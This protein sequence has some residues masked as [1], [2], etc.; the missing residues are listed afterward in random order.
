MHFISTI[1][2]NR[3]GT[4]YSHARIIHAW[5]SY[6][7]EK[8]PIIQ[9]TS[10]HERKSLAFI[11]RII[12][13]YSQWK[14]MFDNGSTFGDR[15]NGTLLRETCFTC[16]SSLQMYRVVPCFNV[17]LKIQFSGIF[18]VS[19]WSND[20]TEHGTRR[21]KERQTEKEEGKMIYKKWTG[22]GLVEALSKC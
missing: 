13:L 12:G 16:Q 7:L 18:R 11:V 10:V 3:L 6:I 20:P 15:R 4:I 14:A 21:E 8:R 2:Y 17:S 22:L 19:C 1:C 9:W 5:V